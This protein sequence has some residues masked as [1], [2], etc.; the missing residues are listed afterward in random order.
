MRLGF[1]AKSTAKMFNIQKQ[2]QFTIKQKQESEL[3]LKLAQQK[4]EIV[5]NDVTFKH[6]DRE[7][8]LNKLIR[9]S[10]LYDKN[11]PGAK[12]INKLHAPFHIT[13]DVTTRSTRRLRCFGCLRFGL[14][15][16]W[17]VQGSR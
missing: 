14:F 17:H 4:N 3:K 1:E 16:S 7:N 12:A 13:I 10:S 8:A 2:R 15:D 5:L 11:S 9:A 6:D